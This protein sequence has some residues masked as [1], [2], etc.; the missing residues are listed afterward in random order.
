MP[1]MEMMAEVGIRRL[2]MFYAKEKSDRLT[3]ETGVG[4]EPKAEEKQGVSLESLNQIGGLSSVKK[5]SKRGHICFCAGFPSVTCINPDSSGPIAGCSL[6]SSF[7]NAHASISTSQ[8]CG[9]TFRQPSLSLDVPTFP[10]GV[11]RLQW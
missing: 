4:L 2:P 10:Q 8:P 11:T 5:R 6:P 1:I 7:W 9:A 3:D